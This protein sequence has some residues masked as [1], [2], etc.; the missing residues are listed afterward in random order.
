ML[1]LII[2]WLSWLAHKSSKKLT[3]TIE[4]AIINY[5]DTIYITW[6]QLRVVKINFPRVISVTIRITVADPSAVCGHKDVSL[7]ASP[8]FNSFRGS[9]VIFHNIT[10]WVPK[11]D[12]AI[13]KET[14][15]RWGTVKTNTTNLISREIIDSQV[16][17]VTGVVYY[18]YFFISHHHMMVWWRRSKKLADDCF[19]RQLIAVTFTNQIPLS[20]EGKKHILF[21]LCKRHNLIAYFEWY[22]FLGQRGVW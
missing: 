21:S 22:L 8:Y 13:R 16:V 12:I 17:G 6:I 11:K 20:I 18:D 14:E 15:L 10:T 19:S 3:L 9:D 7:F 1:I 4:C 2:Y 5:H